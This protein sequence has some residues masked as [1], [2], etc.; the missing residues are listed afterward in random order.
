VGLEDLA[1]LLD[2]G[3]SSG[4]FRKDYQPWVGDALYAPLLKRGVEIRHQDIKDNPG[5]DIVGDLT[6][7]VFIEDL[8]ARS[9]RSVLCANLLEHVREPDRVCRSLVKIVPPGG[10]LFVTCPFRFP[11]H[12]DPIDT[13]FRP[14]VETLASLFPSTEIV[15]S[16]IVAC[17]TYFSHLYPM[18][19][20]WKA[21]LKH[22]ARLC[23]PFYAPPVWLIKVLHLPWLFRRLSA[24]CVVLKKN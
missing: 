17:G 6:D 3:S 13:R 11:Y 22:M 7:P 8:A 18:L 9:F 2:L 24:T 20:K 16:E 23:L 4:D 15:A 1:P 19:P 21:L 5:V 12:P 14:D 10:Y